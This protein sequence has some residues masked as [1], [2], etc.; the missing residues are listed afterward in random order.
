MWREV[1][2]LS[3]FSKNNLPCSLSCCTGNKMISIHILCFNTQQI[4][5]S[6]QYITLFAAFHQRCLCFSAVNRTASIS[7]G[8]NTQRT[9]EFAFFFCRVERC[10]PVCRNSK[11]CSVA[12]NG[13]RD[14]A[15]NSRNV[16]CYGHCPI[17]KTIPQVSNRSKKETPSTNSSKNK[18]SLPHILL[19]LL[20]LLCQRMAFWTSC[21]FQKVASIKDAICCCN[22][23]SLYIKALFLSLSLSLSLC[24]ILSLSHSL[25]LSFSRSLFLSLSLSLC[26]HIHI[27]I[28]TQNTMCS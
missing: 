9:V 4:R 7:K 1:K 8:G 27:C 22:S 20:L 18:D 21:K 6:T 5:L 11:S 3:I 25:I 26:I 15:P 14:H 16:L 12:N 24:L 10:R 17:I 28:Y 2:F 23:I 19:S 13:A